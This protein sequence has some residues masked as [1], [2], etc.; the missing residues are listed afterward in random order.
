MAKKFKDYDLDQPFLLPPDIRDWV[1]PGHFARFVDELV[2]RLN[3][4]KFRTTYR[5]GRGQP[6]YNPEMMFRVLLYSFCRGVFT[7]RRMEEM[8][9]DDIGARYLANDQHPDFT[10]FCNFRKRHKEA[11]QDAFVQVVAICRELGLCKLGQVCIDGTTMKANA[12]KAKTIETEKLDELIERDRKQ[13]ADLFEQWKAGDEHSR[14]DELPAELKDIQS[15]LAALDR[16]K[17]KLER[18]AQERHEVEMEAFRAE[19]AARQANHD[20][21]WQTTSETSAAQREGGIYINEARAMR[22]LKQ[23]E[24]AEKTGIE[25][26]RLGQ[27]EEGKRYPSAEEIEKLQI[28]LEMTNLIFKKSGPTPRPLRPRKAPEKSYPT[29]VNKT[30][31]DSVLLHRRGGSTTQGFNAQFAVDAER[32]IVVAAMVSMDAND[33]H[34]LVPMLKEVERVT[35]CTP[36]VAAA[37]SAYY[38]KEAVLEATSMGIDLYVPPEKKLKLDATNPCP[39]AKAMREKVKTDEGRA[40][41]KMRSA[42]VEPPFGRVKCGLGLKEFKTRGVA[43]VST[44]WTLIGMA[45]NVLKIF[46]YGELQW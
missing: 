17:E 15:R 30:D 45:H 16:V 33:S 10:S 36:D 43:N 3:L 28:A 29:Y 19:E 14:D 2:S 1:K 13:A 35:G 32:Q 21:A 39:V 26:R 8:T 42:T 4:K 40:R 31:P 38:S 27:F 7:S 25:R 22:G 5:G 44:E 23:E 24:L 6:P 46:A 9:Y 11:I 41:R 18:E 34:N 37:D 20:Q 12:S